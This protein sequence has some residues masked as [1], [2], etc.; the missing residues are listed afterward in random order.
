MNKG[1]FTK[2]RERLE[3]LWQLRFNLDNCKVLH[4]SAN[5]DNPRNKYYLDGT[6]L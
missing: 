5:Y 3:G 1:S 2:I 4:I 6:E